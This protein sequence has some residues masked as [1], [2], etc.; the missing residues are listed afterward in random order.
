MNN[1]LS[2]LSKYVHYRFGSNGSLLTTYRIFNYEIQNFLVL[3]SDILYLKLTWNWK[4]F[5]TFTILNSKGENEFDWSGPIASSLYSLLPCVLEFH[6][7]KK[8][9]WSN[10]RYFDRISVSSTW[11]INSTTYVQLDNWMDSAWIY[12]VFL[13]WLWLLYRTRNLRD[14]LGIKLVAFLFEFN[15]L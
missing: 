8:L 14:C 9:W 13:L 2:H 3:Q 1:T 5:N 7:Q 11:L 12:P 6:I 10:F 15:L 4:I